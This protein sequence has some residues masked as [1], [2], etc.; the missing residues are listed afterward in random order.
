MPHAA[1]TFTLPPVQEVEGLLP[2]E[3]PEI[4]GTY[5]DAMSS[6]TQLGKAVKEA[7]DE[8]DTLGTLVS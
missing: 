8:L 2:E 5:K 7:C 4:P 1:P 6:N 3:D